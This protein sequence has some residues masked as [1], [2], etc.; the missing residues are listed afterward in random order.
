M[1][2]GFGKVYEFL[3]L[4]VR[5]PYGHL[6]CFINEKSAVPPAGTVRGAKKLKREKQNISKVQ[7]APLAIRIFSS[8]NSIV[9][10]MKLLYRLWKSVCKGFYAL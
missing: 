9:Q 3:R 1:F 2:I 6:R 7:L 10:A 8:Y 4:L 5:R